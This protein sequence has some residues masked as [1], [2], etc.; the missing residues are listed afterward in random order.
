MCVCLTDCESISFRFSD[1]YEVVEIGHE[2]K[3]TN[4]LDRFYFS[5]SL[6]FGLFCDDFDMCSLEHVDVWFE[7][8]LK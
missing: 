3:S 8:Q 4:N 5:S 1:I 7:D 6:Y 2:Y